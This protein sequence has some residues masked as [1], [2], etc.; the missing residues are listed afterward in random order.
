MEAI[1]NYETNMLSDILSYICDNAADIDFEL[2]TDELY[3]KLYDELWAEDSVTGNGS[4]DGYG[5]TED[6]AELY[7]IGNRKLFI[8]AANEFGEPLA[9]YV[10]NPIRA[11]ITIRC[12]MLSQI[13]SECIEMFKK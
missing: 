6:K 11:D 1:Y 4:E 7:L 12:Y 5:L 2:P 13:L 10:E 8:E 3:E 9:T